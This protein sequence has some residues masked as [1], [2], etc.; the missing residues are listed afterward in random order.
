MPIDI[1]LTKDRDDKDL[2]KQKLSVNT[3]EAPRLDSDG[4]TD[5]NKSD[6]FQQ[7]KDKQPKLNTRSHKYNLKTSSDSFLNNKKNSY[8][9]DIVNRNRL[10]Y[11]TH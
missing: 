11:C 4:A 9:D 2:P 3:A 5:V 1:D 6:Y 7:K 10:F 8:W